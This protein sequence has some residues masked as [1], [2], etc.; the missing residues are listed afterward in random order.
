MKPRIAL[1]GLP[2]NLT[3]R[4]FSVTEGRVAD[5]L[6]YSVDTAQS[7]HI[8]EYV[9]EEIQVGCKLRIVIMCSGICEYEHHLEFNG[10]D[11]SHVPNFKKET[12]INDQEASTD[13]GLEYWKKWHPKPLH[14]KGLLDER[15]AIFDK[16]I[17]TEPMWRSYYS[18]SKIDYLE[19]FHKLWIGLNAYA[20]HSTGERSDKRKILALVK[21][22]K[23]QDAFRGMLTSKETKKSAENWRSLQK[24]TGVNMTSDIVRDEIALRVTWIDFLE[25]AKMATG[26]FT[27]ISSELD[28]LAFLT[29]TSKEGAFRDIFRKY[30][31]YM[32]SEEG[33]VHRFNMADAFCAPRAPESVNQFGRLVFHN[34]FKESAAGNLFDLEDYFGAEYADN[35]YAG[36][37]DNSLKA[38]EEIDPLFFRYLH[39]LYK[40]RCAYFHGDLPLS[41][42]NNK[43]A[44]TAYQS[45][46]ELFPAIL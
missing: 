44:R 40:F 35:P 18:D 46:H 15:A 31:K 22:V 42:Q 45:L 28:G 10:A 1:F 23:L 16:T 21:D 24:A 30:H 34:P 14:D 5:N 32:A 36:Q 25:I 8:L 7:D 4:V 37:A 6:I 43:L 13:W 2:P 38:W 20:T 41:K 17:V 3:I 29:S 33:I 19:K 12:N 26:T 39:V 11:I 9:T 27:D